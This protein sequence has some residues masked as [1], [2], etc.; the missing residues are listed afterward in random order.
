MQATLV[1]NPWRPGTHEARE[2]RA[3]VRT[4][5][6]QQPTAS[7]CTILRAWH[8]Q[9]PE[10]TLDGEAAAQLR[11]RITQELTWAR[12]SLQEW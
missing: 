5:L 3:S 12:L 1:A 6:A 10:P 11:Q 8:E 4:I 2:L 9:H 7:G